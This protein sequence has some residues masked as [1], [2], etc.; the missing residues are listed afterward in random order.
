M[1]DD[2]THES[3]MGAALGLARRGLG[4][5][6]P[7][8]AVGCVIVRP[9][10]TGGRI[11]GRG[12]TQPGGRPHAEAEALRRAGAAAKGA[13]AYVSLEPCSHH[14]KTPPCADALVNAGIAHAVVAAED[15]DPR[16]SGNG[17]GA[18]KAAGIAVTAG[19]LQDQ[20]EDLNAGFILRVRDGRPLLTLKTAT[21]LDG[22]IAAG[23]GHSQWITSEA[24]RRWSHGLR[25]CHDAVMVGIGTVLADDPNLTCRLP[26]LPVRPPLRIVVDGQARL[27]LSSALVKT[28]RDAPVCL[29]TWPGTEVPAKL[30]KVVDVLEAPAGR[31]GRPDMGEVLVGLAARGIT[32]VLVEGGAGI[33]TSL[34]RADLVDRIAWFRAS[35]I[36]GGD[37]VPALRDLG[38]E[39]VGEARRFHRDAVYAIGDDMLETYRR[40]A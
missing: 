35:S 15:P 34:L 24:A 21:S 37:G 36:I 13:L 6:W 23:S 33:A 2:P 9:D 3:Y 11:V 16:V 28:A 8:P 31:D 18:L 5:V 32:R 26:G 39:S 29:V 19:V 27:P 7:N 10:G 4:N 22:R 1:F 20:A 17:I 30:A 12:W 40:R 38:V 14:G 25:A